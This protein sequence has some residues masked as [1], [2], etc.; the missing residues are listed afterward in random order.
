MMNFNPKYNIFFF[1][2]IKTDKLWIYNLIQMYGVVGM[3]GIE[4]H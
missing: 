4:S 3:L 2:L 1:L